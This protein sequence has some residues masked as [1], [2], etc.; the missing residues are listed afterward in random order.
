MEKRNSLS[1]IKKSHLSSHELSNIML[2]LKMHIDGSIETSRTATAAAIEIQSLHSFG[3][4]AVFLTHAKE[5]IRSNVQYGLTQALDVQVVA[6][7]SLN[8]L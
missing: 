6:L 5:I 8:R 7:Y 3:L 1:G 4:D 2:K